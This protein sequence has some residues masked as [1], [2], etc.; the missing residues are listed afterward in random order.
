MS[1]WYILTCFLPEASPRH[2][3]ITWLTM[4]HVHLAHL[5]STIAMLIHANPSCFTQPYLTWPQHLSHNMY[6]KDQSHE[7]IDPYHLAIYAPYAPTCTISQAKHCIA[8]YHHNQITISPST[9]SMASLWSPLQKTW[10]PHGHR[11]D[12]TL[13]NGSKLHKQVVQTNDLTQWSE[14]LAWSDPCNPETSSDPY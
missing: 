7:V 9:S 4:H 3:G 1:N 6:A 2:K 13:R 12:E 14:R 8:W 11:I 10:R 5:I